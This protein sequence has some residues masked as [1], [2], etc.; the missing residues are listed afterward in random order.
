MDIESLNKAFSLNDGNSQL[1]FIKGEGGIPLINVKNEHATSVISLQGAHVLSWKPHAEEE[2][3]WLS[4]EATFSFG[5][6]VRGGIPICWP[7]F[8]AHESNA[9]FPAHGFARTVLWTV[10]DTEI[11]STGEIQI[12]FRLVTNE[13]E[14]NI[15]HMWPQATVAEYRLIIGKT[16]ILELTTYNNSEENI[17]IGQAFHTYFN[18]GDIN[19]TTVLGLE[20]KTYLDKVA[21]FTSKVQSGAITIDKEVDRVYIETTDDITIDNEQRKI[22]IKKKGS[23]S[24]VVWNPWEEVANKMGDLGEKGYRKMLCVES[25]NAI[26]DVIIIEAGGK[27]K[28]RVEYDIK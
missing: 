25:A 4:E 6:S 14:E 3:I 1:C 7:W 20:D 17:T 11:L 9:A 24:T 13:L 26:N 8:G 28:L 10:A 5:K 2:V 21:G 23:S 19:K 18:I 16:L 27:A 15:Q 22:I 12:V